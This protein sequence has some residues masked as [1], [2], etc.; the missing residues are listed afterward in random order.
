MPALVAQVFNLVEERN[1]LVSLVGE[2]LATL[3]LPSNQPCHVGM[4]AGLVQAWE[5][6]RDV[7]LAQEIKAA[8]C[9]KET[10]PVLQD[11]GNRNPEHG[12]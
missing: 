2:I 9:L 7:I 1:A 3:S 6:R 11:N 8:A 4:M 5:K 10:R 12:S